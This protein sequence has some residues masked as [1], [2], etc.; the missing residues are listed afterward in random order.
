MKKQVTLW[1][2]ALLGIIGVCAIF[3]SLRAITPEQLTTFHTSVPF[4]VFTMMVAFVDSFNPCNLFAFL[5]LLGVLVQASQ[6]K[7]RVYLIGTIF[8]TVVYAFYYLVMAAWL[9]IFKFI[10][11]VEPLRVSVG[12]L[13]I[14]AGIINGKELFAFNQGISLMISAKHKNMLYA[15]MRHVREIIASGTLSLLILTTFTLAI[16][17]SF[18][19]L[20]CTSG[21]P[22]IYTKVLAAKYTTG[23]AYH[24]YYLA[25]YNLIY[26]LPL[27]FI[28]ALITLSVRS[29]QLSEKQAGIIK[30]ISGI[31]MVVL[32]IILLV[33]PELLMS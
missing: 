32:G 5:L 11:L 23:S 33:R 30:F 27:L 19:E 31:V 24:Y 12:I 7:F 2:V 9:N 6:T 17:T 25:L 15:K 28:I 14:I 3:V 26:I 13:A 4:F 10:G 29:K 22:I 18:I 20:I 8:I 16:F 1:L 21:F